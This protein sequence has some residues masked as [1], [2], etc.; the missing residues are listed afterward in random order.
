MTTSSQFGDIPF[1]LRVGVIGSVSEFDGDLLRSEIIK[2]LD[3][4][5]QTVLREAKHTGLELQ[6]DP[7]TDDSLNTADVLFV[8]NSSPASES[9]LSLAREQGRPIISLTQSKPQELSVEEGH[10]LNAHLARALERFNA[11]PI[12]DTEQQLYIENVYND[13]FT[14]DDGISANIKNTIR[15]QLLPYYVRASRVAKSN[16]RLYRFAGLLVYSFSALAVAAVAIGT[17]V[18]GESVSVWAFGAELLL[19]I[20]ILST[21]VYTNRKRAHKNWI[22]ARYVAERI[23]TGVVLTACG[24]ETS[25]IALPANV[26]VTGKPEQWMIMA[27]NE[28]TRRLPRLNACHG[29]GVEK[30]VAFV[31]RFWL[32]AQIRFHTDKAAQAKRMSHRLER[33]G[34]ICFSAA[35]AAAALHLTLS[36]LHIES[37]EHPLTFAAIFLPAAGAAIGGIRTHREYSRLAIRSENMAESLRALDRRIATVA[38][39]KDLAAVLVQI[40]ELTLLELQDWL[41]LM[42]VSKLEAA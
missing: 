37:L 25:V 15:E 16:Q 3:E 26:G 34:F 30:Y 41:T 42:S 11:H 13:F 12:P 38:T 2:L 27:F 35:L 10:G 24:V 29:G 20:T 21:I 32:A 39:P 31:R 22:Q 6:F 7:L 8:A 23:R 40:E 18:R 33:A 5:S 4:Q 36:L 28:I 19:L 9:L 1:R 17:L 14:A